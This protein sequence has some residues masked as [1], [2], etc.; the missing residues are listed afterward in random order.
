M[1]NLSFVIWLLG[2]PAVNSFGEFVEYG[3]LQ[4]DHPEGIQV[5][6]ELLNLVIWVFVAVHLFETK[7]QSK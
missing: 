3:I 1:R 6:A 2:F 4:R 7:E 5:A